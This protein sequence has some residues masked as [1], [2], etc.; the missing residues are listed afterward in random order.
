M[1]AAQ[2]RYCSSG[3]HMQPLTRFRRIGTGTDG[4]TRYARFCI[5][6]E[7]KRLP[8]M[9]GVDIDRIHYVRGAVRR[10]KHG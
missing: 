7:G 4:R 5:A 3:N 8:P 9:S 2:T 1:T 6:C 10:R